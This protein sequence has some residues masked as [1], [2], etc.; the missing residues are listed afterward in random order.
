MAF[1]IRRLGPED[2]AAYGEM[3]DLFALGFEDPETYSAARPEAEYVAGR[4]ADPGFVALVAWDGAVAV[5]ALA[6]Y[7]LQKFEQAR[8]EMYIYDLAVHPD[9]RRKRVAT[10]LIEALKPIA[11]AAG[12]SVI[13][14]QADHGD[15]PAITLYSGL[16]TREDVLH[17]DIPVA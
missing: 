1:E 12:A 8:A 9:H 15:D 6:A 3:L 5:G 16:G 14:V 10:G 2:A 13:F 11:R 17:F 4:L 7:T